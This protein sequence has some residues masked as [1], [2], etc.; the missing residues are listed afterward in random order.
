MAFAGPAISTRPP[1]ARLRM[2]TL[3]A[4][5][6]GLG[7]VATGTAISLAGAPVLQ[8]AAFIVVFPAGLV[9]VTASCG[10]GPAVLAAVAGGL[11]FDFIFVPPAFEFAVPNLKD[12]LPLVIM[13]LMAA[14]ASVFAEQLRA[15]A[16]RAESQADVERL[17]NALL[18]ALSHDLRTPLGTLL[19]AST[20][21]CDDRLGPEERR[22]FSLAVADEARHLSRLV[23]A[24]L[25]LTRL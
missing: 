15:Q 17:R 12:G 2:G 9:I 14:V 19:G 3:R 13:L 20:A 25:E 22:A 21:L 4:Y 18:S 7:V 6:A 16:Q 8:T 11:A 24:L 1:G 23:A 10:I 5:L